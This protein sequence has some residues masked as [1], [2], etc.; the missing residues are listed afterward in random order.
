MDTKLCKSCR[1][2]K[3]LAE[4]E[5]QTKNGKVY[6]RHRCLACKRKRYHETKY[7]NAGAL[8]EYRRKDAE[9]RKKA[10]AAG[11]DA[12]KFIYWDSRKTDRKHGRKND[13]TKEYIATQIA[14]GCSYCGEKSLRMTLDRIDNTLGHTQT[15]TVPA[16]I[17]C[18]YVRGNMPYEAWKVV[19]RAMKRAVEKELFGDWTGRVR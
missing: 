14:K 15:N 10:R 1:L 2:S 4:M 18:N 19:A 7:A 13:L 12:T 8:Q 11:T 9:R 6:Y 16:C 5:K 17:R 3:P